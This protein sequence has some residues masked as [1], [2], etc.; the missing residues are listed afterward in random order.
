MNEISIKRTE[1]IINQLHKLLPLICSII[2]ISIIA[3]SC[4][5]NDA[6]DSTIK[7]NADVQY[8]DG[9]FLIKNKDNFYW[10]DV[11]MLLYYDDDGLSDAYQ[12]N[13][14]G[15][16]HIQG[17]IIV[18][19]WD[20]INSEGRRFTKQYPPV[21]FVIQAETPDGEKAEFITIKETGDGTEAKLKK[22]SR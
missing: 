12:Y 17:T 18:Q 20:F 4:V 19:I 1:S 13:I 3:I 11:C 16:V 5:N 2:F 14:E 22:K 9:N 21:K 10:S 8:G 6:T 15:R 7:L